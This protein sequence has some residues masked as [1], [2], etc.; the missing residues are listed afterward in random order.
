VIV[1][2]SLSAYVWF[3]QLLKLS[4]PKPVIKRIRSLLFGRAR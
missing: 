4:E 2:V 1:A 3:S